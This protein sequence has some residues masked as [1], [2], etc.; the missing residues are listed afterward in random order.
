ME[1][2]S[3]RG[4]PDPQR[5]NAL[6]AGGFRRRT[7]PRT[8]VTARDYVSVLRRRW[9][10][11]ALTLVLALAVAVAG[12]LLVPRPYVAKSTVRVA[13]ASS[14][15]EPVRSDDLSYSDRLMNTYRTIAAS[16]PVRQALAARLHV[17]TA[18]STSISIPANPELIQIPAKDGDAR[19]AQRT[20]NEL[21]RLLVARVS[22]LAS[23]GQRAAGAQLRPR[24]QALSARID[25]Q[26]QERARLAAIPA[27]A[28]TT[29][30]ASRLG[31]LTEHI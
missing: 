28:R 25:S 30:E 17:Q 21:A 6:L 5:R 24:L 14:Q 10:S 18:P 15:T 26:S 20:A 1:A 11:V 13:T 3:R 9:I 27:A 12:A 7:R 4:R 22:G 19:L 2:R 31:E 8:T 16:K 23:V 29:A